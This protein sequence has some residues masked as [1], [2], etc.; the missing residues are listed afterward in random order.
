MR[1]TLE[2]A[3]D[4]GYGFRCGPES[5]EE[6]WSIAG[7]TF[8]ISKLLAALPAPAHIELKMH[9]SSG[10]LNSHKWE[11]VGSQSGVHIFLDSVPKGKL[12]GG[13]A[14]YSVWSCTLQ[15]NDAIK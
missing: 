14:I 13:T 9:L 6:Q 1:L 10:V 3:S 15:T 7:T 11:Y 2:K 4:K 5:S 8:R 12:T